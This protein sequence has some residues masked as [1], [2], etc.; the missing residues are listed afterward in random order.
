MTASMKGK[1]CWNEY[2]IG[3]VL[4]TDA[5]EV[6]DHTF[7]ASHTPVK[8]YREMNT[9]IAQSNLVPYSE[10]QFLEDFLKRDN[11][12]FATVLGD[13]GTG[14][15]HLIRWISARIPSTDKRK[16]ILIPRFGANLR[17]ILQLILEGM[18]G[19]QFD[20]Y[21]ERLKRVDDGLT[22]ESARETLLG[23]LA[24]A[25]GPNG[26]H[27]NQNTTLSDEEHFMMESLPA[28]FHDPFFR[29]IL[30]EDNGIIHDLTDH[31]IGAKDKIQRIEK[32]RQFTVDD[33]PTN[34]LD[35]GKA[36]SDARDIY[37]ALMEDDELKE[38]AVNWINKY[39]NTSIS[40]MLN[41]QG[42]D[43]VNMMNDIRAEL[44]KQ[45]IELV[46]LFEDFAVVQGID[47]QLLEALLIRPNGADKP[48]CP[49][50]V[51]MACTT[52]YFESLRDTIQT[53]VELK[54]TL[55]VET[56]DMFTPNDMATFVSRYLN[57][58]RYEDQEV[59][60]WYSDQL[61]TGEVKELPSACVQ[62]ECPFIE[63]CHGSFGDDEDK[64][65]YPFNKQAILTMYNRLFKEANPKF[66]PRTM[67]KDVIKRT[68][69]DYSED[70][71]TGTFPPTSM[72]E[73]FGGKTR[74]R[75]TALEIQE[76]NSLDPNSAERREVLL[77]FW[78]DSNKI[79]NL[80]K[81]IHEAF[82]FADINT[83]TPKAGLGQGIG[84]FDP[85]D[86]D[87]NNLEPI[88]PTPKRAPKPTQEPA[89]TP[90]QKDE[91]PKGVKANIQAI[92]TWKND[93]SL[94]QALA[95]MLREHLFDAIN[96]YIDWDSEFLHFISLRDIEGL[97]KPRHINFERSTSFSP[98]MV[99]LV[100]PLS[101]EQLNDTAIAFQGMIYFR[102]YGH[103]KFNR[104]SQ[105]YRYFTRYLHRWSR[106]VLTRLKTITSK[107]NQEIPIVQYATEIM[108]IGA[109][110]SGRSLENSVEQSIDTL[111]YPIKDAQS[112][113]SKK[114][115][116]LQT[117]IKGKVEEIKQH[118]YTRI[119]IYKGQRQPFKLMD[120]TQLIASV[121][122]VKKGHFTHELGE[123]ITEF[124][125]LLRTHKQIRDTFIN[126]VQEE[127]QDKMEWLGYVEEAF[128][129]GLDIETTV[130]DLTMAMQMATSDGSFRGIQKKELFWDLVASVESLPIKVWAEQ[131][132][133]IGEEENVVKKAHLL[134]SLDTDEMLKVQAFIEN[135]NKF[136]E[137]STISVEKDIF[138]LEQNQKTTGTA[139]ITEEIQQQFDLLVNVMNGMKW[140]DSNDSNKSEIINS[141]HR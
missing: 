89:S 75:L 28:L 126:V 123:T 87:G 65:L 50:R 8:M 71:R 98:N 95:Q 88:T 84:D 29:K 86:E 14:K 4:E 1:I 129:E 141:T 24:I 83:D 97:W 17:K 109:I 118:L 77:E 26:P 117:D 42:G 13:I 52:G 2:G 85:T 102:H 19:P 25:I 54:V 12:M 31:V 49:I 128:G 68:L 140:R 32:R 119:G 69:E 90:P 80:P 41:L 53:R 116:K 137:Q 101:N 131:I 44:A 105:Y 74:N 136:L 100:L 63:K 7:L 73:R 114:W 96:D 121:E 70:I 72:F 120:S 45:D 130:E 60:Q 43:L 16:V 6:K 99:Q 23:N 124:S 81:P 76:L 93:G 22:A 125:T 134:G 61:I 21:R 59:Q 82:H 46:L 103:W 51:A 62:K 3:R 5:L 79:I 113:R 57:V 34:V 122:N 39:I 15:T 40:Q 67:I 35:F 104:G 64:G 36:S 132:Q 135:A 92:E 106:H 27:K 33:L 66:N 108:A 11:Y 94:P 127:L 18:E 110:M 20:D 10:S 55:D 107:N 133:A 56:G 30:L 48:L 111:F 37:S 9:S 112:T 138:D 91:L 58:L 38:I 115:I 78:S 139:T 47:F